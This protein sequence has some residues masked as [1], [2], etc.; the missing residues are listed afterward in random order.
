MLEGVQFISD[1]LCTRTSTARTKTTL[2]VS[3]DPRKTREGVSLAVVALLVGMTS[4]ARTREGKDERGGERERAD[5][6]GV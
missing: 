4:G 6:Q 1:K 2:E 5:W 3:A